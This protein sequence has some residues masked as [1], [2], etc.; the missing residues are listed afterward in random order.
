MQDQHGQF[1]SAFLIE[2]VIPLTPQLSIFQY[3][4][5]ADTLLRTTKYVLQFTEPATS[6]HGYHPFSRPS[7]YFLFPISTFDYS[8]GYLSPASA[9]DGALRLGS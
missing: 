8:P 2:M 1:Y 9:S 5:S 7:F 4:F 6:A 3:L